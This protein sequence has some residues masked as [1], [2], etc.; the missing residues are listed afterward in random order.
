M[1]FSSYSIKIRSSLSFNFAFRS[2]ESIL[3]VEKYHRREAKCSDDWRF[4]I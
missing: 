3:E 1:G 4:G 2:I